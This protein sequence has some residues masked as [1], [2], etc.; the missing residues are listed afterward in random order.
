M[1]V[2]GFLDLPG[3]A[4]HAQVG[5]GILGEIAGDEKDAIEAP[6]GVHQGA[7]AQLPAPWPAGAGDMDSA[8]IQ[9]G[10]RRV[11]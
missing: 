9:L 6:C 1:L 5:A 4:G 2:A 3:E 7:A 8:Q 11:T 10:A